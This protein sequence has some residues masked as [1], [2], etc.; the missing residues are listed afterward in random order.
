MNRKKVMKIV[1]TLFMIASVLSV[2]SRVLASGDSIDI[3]NASAPGGSGNITNVIASVLWVVQII[4]YT[5]AVIL[6]IML[7]IK[8]MT[9]SP[10]GKAEVKKSA[11]IYVIGAVMVFFAGA[12]V[13]VIR[14][15]NIIDPAKG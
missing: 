11:V 8:F 15:S 10:E 6:L 4:C 12:I 1:S 2:F 13:T 9:A 3:P 7:G 14:N 5:A